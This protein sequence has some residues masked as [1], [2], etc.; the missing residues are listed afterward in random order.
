MSKRSLG[1]TAI[2]LIALMGLIAVAGLDNLPKRVHA[3]AQSAVTELAAD[4]TR[5]ERERGAIVQALTS[6][7]ALFASQAP[8]FRNRLDAAA[9]R[10]AEAESHALKLKGLEQADRRQDADAAESEVRQLNTARSAALAEAQAIRKQTE[11]WI[12]Y[13]QH[14]PELLAQMEQ[15]HTAIAAFDVDAAASAAKKAE[16]DWP[17]KKADLEARLSALTGLKQSAEKTWEGSAQARAKAE[18]KDW[19]AVD[20][21]GLIAA[22]D[23][24]AALQSEL[25][26]GADSANAL[27][28]QLYVNWDKLLLEVNKDRER[29][30]KV[31]IVRTKYPDATLQNG[32]VSQ[33]ERWENIAANRAKDLERNV[34]MVIERKPAGKYDTESEKVAQEPGYAYIAPPG[35]ANQYGSW[36]NG[37]WNWLPQYLILSQLLRGPSYPPVRMD[38]YYGYDRARR[39]GGTWYGHSRSPG[40]SV[41]GALRRALE[42]FGGGRSSGPSVDSGSS[43]PRETWKWGGGSGGFGG[44][45]YQSR[46]S[47]GGSRYES[48]R[49]SGGFGSRG[50]TR[51]FGGRSFGRGGRR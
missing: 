36:N 31:R 5:F 22:A 29:E 3:S 34:G 24:L 10:L 48:R 38:D 19:A 9:A 25:R 47:Y 39:M 32:Q 13:K 11:Q 14:M 20:Y 49:P 51:G 30:Q 33:E 6:D 16:T 43:R 8:E 15:R 23:R 45:R 17:A 2:I 42:G 50:Y 41:G 46:G 26:S 35:Q 40:S 18:A 28:S 21:G 37:V 44:S 27:A 7:P 1:A 12:G 4:R